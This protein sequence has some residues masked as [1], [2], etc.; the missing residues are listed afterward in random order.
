MPYYDGLLPINGTPAF[1]LSSDEKKPLFMDMLSELTYLH[2]KNSP[3]YHHIVSKINPLPRVR[4]IDDFPFIPVRLFK[5][6]DL[7]SVPK[8]EIFK[9]VMS[10][11]TTGGN[12]SKIYLDKTNAA[13]QSKVLG[14]I[15]AEFLGSN[16]KPMVVVDSD[17]I[18][19][20]RVQFNARTAGVIGFSMFG[21]NHLYCLDSSMGLKKK[22]LEEFLLEKNESGIFAFGFTFVIWQFLL[23]Y[24]KKRGIRLDFGENSFLLHGGGW[25]RLVDEGVSNDEFKVALKERCGFGRIHSYYGMVE[26]AGTIFMECEDGFYHTSNYSDILI[27]DPLTF[28]VLPFGVS[29]LIQVISLLPYS[30]PGHNLLTEDLGVCFGEDNCICGR[31]GKYFQVHGR[32]KSSE[33]RGCSDVRHY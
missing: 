33:P 19:K 13:M 4:T 22:V 12:V 24:L 26:Q 9:V 10:S 28:R 11:G 6:L 2:K 32:M 18:I 14:I 27:R 5:F 30:Y 17:T 21:F 3:V 23:G 25:K 16:R 29:G 7:V 1:S 8:S 31:K 20:D 15:M